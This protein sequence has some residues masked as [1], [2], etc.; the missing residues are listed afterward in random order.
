M[1]SLSGGVGTRRLMRLKAAAVYLDMH[2]WT[3]RQLVQRGEIPYI[4]SGDH[5]SA[6]RFDIH[7]LDRWIEAHRIGG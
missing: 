3:V 5:T 7:D 4:S 2:P 1:N 6:W